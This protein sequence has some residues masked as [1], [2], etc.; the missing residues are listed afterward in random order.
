M[1]AQTTLDDKAGG[2]RK[3]LTRG[4]FRECDRRPAGGWAGWLGRLG[5]NKAIQAMIG[6]NGNTPFLQSGVA[7]DWR[8][9]GAQRW[10]SSR[11][12]AAKS[13]GLRAAGVAPS[14]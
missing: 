2:V 14:R 6:A 11:T 5:R 4:L 1:F 8:T 13:A 12:K 7:P 9:I 3:A 10:T